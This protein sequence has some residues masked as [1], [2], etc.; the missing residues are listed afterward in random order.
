[1]EELIKR[2]LDILSDTETYKTWQHTRLDTQEPREQ[3]AEEFP[4]ETLTE[5]YSRIVSPYPEAIINQ[6]LS[7]VF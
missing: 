4:F 5:K 3:V 2:R 7:R 6:E 1:M